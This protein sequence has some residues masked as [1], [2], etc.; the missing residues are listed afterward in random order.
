MK[1]NRRSTFIAIANRIVVERGAKYLTLDELAKQAG[2]SKGGILYYFPTKEALLASMVAE[3]VANFT[4]AIEEQAHIHGWLMAYLHVTLQ[5]KNGLASAGALLGAIAN[6]PVLLGPLREAHR[7]W[8]K[9]IEDEMGSSL[10]AA[11]IRLAIDGLWYAEL[12]GI[13]MLDATTRK[14]LRAKLKTDI[15][16]LRTLK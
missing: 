15:S 14:A 16:T 12:F 1:N 6:N 11:Q 5:E 2:V 7:A 13:G 4:S 3:L 9:R 8:M 10:T